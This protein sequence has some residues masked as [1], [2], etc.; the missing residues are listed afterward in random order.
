MKKSKQLSFEG[1]LLRALVG[2]PVKDC[3]PLFGLRI[4]YDHGKTWSLRALCDECLHS[5]EPPARAKNEGRAG[6][7]K[8]DWCGALNEE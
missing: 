3:R 4:S 7:V 6:A 1:K 2:Q 5:I 8:C